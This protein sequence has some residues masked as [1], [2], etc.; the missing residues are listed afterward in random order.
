MALISKFEEGNKISN[1]TKLLVTQ[2]IEVLL[3]KVGRYKKLKLSKNMLRRGAR[4]KLNPFGC[5]VS[6]YTSGLYTG[7]YRIS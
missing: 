1:G 5:I 4:I 3:N 6:L 7:D 2:A